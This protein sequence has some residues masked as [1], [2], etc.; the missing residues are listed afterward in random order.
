MQHTAIRTYT[1]NKHMHKH[2]HTCGHI[3]QI[4]IHMSDGSRNSAKKDARITTSHPTYIHLS[5]CTCICI[6]CH[7]R[8]AMT[9]T[10][11]KN[12]P[13]HS[14]INMSPIGCICYSCCCHDSIWEFT[15]TGEVAA[16]RWPPSQFIMGCNSQSAQRA[17]NHKSLCKP[18]SEFCV[19][20]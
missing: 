3:E 9:R 1:T 14:W 17:W 11:G 13:I 18:A 15:P 10:C 16:L 4:S 5:A 20:N 8:R 2:I 19:K 6:I 12:S 7:S